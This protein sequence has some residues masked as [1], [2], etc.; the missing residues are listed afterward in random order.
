MF[1]LSIDLV[2]LGEE[3][4]TVTAVLLGDSA[5]KVPSVNHFVEQRF[6][7]ILTR[8]KLEQRFTETNYTR[9]PHVVA[10]RVADT[11]ACVGKIVDCGS[12]NNCAN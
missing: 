4:L 7:E 1:T 8:A 5:Y 10:A 12:K 3:V 6:D 9:H 2:H 11:G